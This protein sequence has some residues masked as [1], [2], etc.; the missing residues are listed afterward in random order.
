VRRLLENVCLRRE[1]PVIP[2]TGVT[3]TSHLQAA[4]TTEHH[5]AN[6]AIGSGS[7]RDQPAQEPDDFGM[8]T[9]SNPSWI[10]RGQTTTI[11]K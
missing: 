11:P 7:A 5:H 1:L 4:L 6:I 9:I 2:A 8:D 3:G 10:L